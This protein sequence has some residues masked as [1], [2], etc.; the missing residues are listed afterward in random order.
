MGIGTGHV[1][2]RIAK[3]RRTECPEH[4]LQRTLV[5]VPRLAGSLPAILL[6]RQGRRSL[7]QTLPLQ[8]RFIADI[9]VRCVYVTEFYGSANSA[10]WRGCTRRGRRRR[11]CSQVAE[12]KGFGPDAAAGTAAGADGA[13]RFCFQESINDSALSKG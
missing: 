1:D 7:Q 10:T 2:G 4:R 8:R 13:L 5:A 12:V 6:D 9:R 3:G 11:I